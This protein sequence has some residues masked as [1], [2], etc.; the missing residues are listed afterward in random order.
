MKPTVLSI[1]GS[2]S[3]GGAGVQADLRCFA[4][5]GVAG[6]TALT[7][8]T[9]QNL[10]GVHRAVGVSPAL[11]EAQIWAVL[12][13]RSV[14]AVKTGML[15]SAAV[16]RRVAAALQAWSGPL[17]VDPVMVATSG[18]RLVAPDG[19]AAYREALMP[20]AAL[21]TPNLDEA[22]VL[23]DSTPKRLRAMSP[24]DAAGCVQQAVARP[25]LLKGGHR[26]GPV[27][28]VLC[29]E[30]STRRFVCPRVDGAHTHG[31]GCMLA[32]AITAYLGRGASLEAACRSGLHFVQAALRTGRSSMPL[33][34]ADLET[35]PVPNA[36]PKENE[37]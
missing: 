2:D 29:T 31:S 13:E 8:I 17:V 6:A 18:A 4:R 10:A 15:W 22:A 32:A 37:I 14:R 21:I 11:V 27:I 26:P 33:A 30:T 36:A 23:I 35:A 7:A 34:L 5:L 20:R 9:A 25:V 12:T 3:S 24:E 28:D 16:I 1:A 19:I